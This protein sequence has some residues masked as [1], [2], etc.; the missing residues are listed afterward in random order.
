MRLQVYLTNDQVW[1]VD[2]QGHRALVPGSLV[3]DFNSVPQGEAQV[4]ALNKYIRQ[5]NVNTIEFLPDTLRLTHDNGMV[6][7]FNNFNAFLYGP[8]DPRAKASKVVTLTVPAGMG[9]TGFKNSHLRNLKAPATW[10]QAAQAGDAQALIRLF[11]TNPTA[12]QILD[13]Q[14]TNQE[15]RSNLVDNFIRNLC[16]HKL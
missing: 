4:A 11:P 9:K 12:D 6:E 13:L 8:F 16:T 2:E 5:N 15:L 3:Q 14:L 1:Y 7:R 10:Q